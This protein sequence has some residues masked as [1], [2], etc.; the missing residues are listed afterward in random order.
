MGWI[1]PLIQESRLYGQGNQVQ[2]HKKY[3]KSEVDF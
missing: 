1:E 3:K 2:F